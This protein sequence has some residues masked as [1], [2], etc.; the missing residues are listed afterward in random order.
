MRENKFDVNKMA[1]GVDSHGKVIEIDNAYPYL[2]FPMTEI[3]HELFYIDFI[4]LN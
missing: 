2:D 4:D 3:E 1:V